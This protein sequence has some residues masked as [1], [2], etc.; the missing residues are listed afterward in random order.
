MEAVLSVRGSREIKDPDK[1]IETGVRALQRVLV[2]IL[3][4][5]FVAVLAA[6]DDLGPAG[7]A[8]REARR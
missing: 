5:G 1:A 4:G 3:V 2:N 6:A 8:R 7:L